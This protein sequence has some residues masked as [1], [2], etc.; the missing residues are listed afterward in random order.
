MSQDKG[1][2]AG[3]GKARAFVMSE[4]ERFQEKLAK[5]NAE[6]LFFRNHEHA[7]IWAENAARWAADG[8][9]A[10][11]QLE[12]FE[13]LSAII[14]DRDEWRTQH[15]NLLS[16]RQSD[17]AAITEIAESAFKEAYQLG[18]LEGYECEP[19]YH[20]DEEGA[21]TALLQCDGT[22]EAWSD[23]RAN[24]LTKASSHVE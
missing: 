5:A 9:Y 2:D 19:R 21:A 6:V 16:V 11:K 4:I 10:A 15:E 20:L 7:D 18:F 3:A 1:Q 12:I 13:T 24:N 8:K 22:S 23:Y 17:L 14:A